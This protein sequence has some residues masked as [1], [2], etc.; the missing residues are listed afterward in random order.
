MIVK[1]IPIK[2]KYLFKHYTTFALISGSKY[3]EEEIYDLING[4]GEYLIISNLKKTFCYLY[5]KKN[6]YEEFIKLWEKA[7]ELFLKGGEKNDNQEA[8]T[9][10]QVQS[11]AAHMDI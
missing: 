8:Q 10:K 2:G 7:K 1:Y 4:Y 6:G 5:A 9:D 11:E 3:E